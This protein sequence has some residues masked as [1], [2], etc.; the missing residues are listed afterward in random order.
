M[1]FLEKWYLHRATAA[2]KKKLVLICNGDPYDGARMNPKE[3][4]R[5]IRNYLAGQFVGATRDE[6]ILSEVIKCLFVRY[7]LGASHKAYPFGIGNQSR[8]FKYF[9]K[10]FREV[11]TLYP[12]FFSKEDKFLL[13]EDELDW[14]LRQ[15]WPLNLDNR[16]SDV[17]GDTFE[18][19]ISST[20]RGQEGQFFTPRNAIRFLVEAVGPSQDETIIDPACGTGGFLSLV[21]LQFAKR[22]EDLKAAKIYGIDKDA[23]LVRLAKIHI[24]L[25]GGDHAKI[26]NTDSIALHNGVNLSDLPPEGEYD[27]VLTNP[28]FGAKIISAKPD[29]ASRYQLARKWQ[30]EHNEASWQIAEEL[31]SRIPPQLLFLEKCVKLLRPGGRGGMV[32]PESL[33]SSRQY[34]FVVAYLQANTNVELITGMPE[35]LFKTSGKGGTHT[36][37]C[38]IVFQKKKNRKVNQATPIFFAEAH[39]CGND[40]RGRIIPKDDLTEIIHNYKLHKSDRLAPDNLMGFAMSPNAIEDYSLSPRRY[41]PSISNLLKKL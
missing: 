11:V 30:F 25:V 5:D 31:R 22:S 17:I 34:R 16:E 28:P 12:D 36:K 38:L 40:S 14:T 19:F 10:I 8:A 29:V 32:V 15:L 39:W 1:R 6:A 33:I 23:F 13:G 9:G 27:V 41:D 4:L 35:E 20:L 37:T 26:T 24:A 21:L 3:T 7:H 2:D 18:L